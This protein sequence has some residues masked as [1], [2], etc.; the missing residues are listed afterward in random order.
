MAL[1]ACPRCHHATCFECVEDICQNSAFPNKGRCTVCR[2][3]SS[4]I[5][6][7]GFMEEV[8]SYSWIEVNG[9]SGFLSNENPNYLTLLSWNSKALDSNR[10]GTLI[11][12]QNIRVAKIILQKEAEFSFPQ[13]RHSLLFSLAFDFP[14]YGSFIH[15]ALG[16]AWKCKFRRCFTVLSDFA[17]S[18]PKP[19]SADALFM[20]L[21][22][23][24]ALG[25]AIEADTL[26]GY[27]DMSVTQLNT[28]GKL[29]ILPDGRPFWLAGQ[30]TGRVNAAT[31]AASFLERG[32]NYKEVDAVL[33]ASMKFATW[34][35]AKMLMQTEAVELP[36]FFG[37]DAVDA[38]IKKW[39]AAFFESAEY[40]RTVHEPSSFLSLE[41]IGRMQAME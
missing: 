3:E 9:R 13:G 14:S 24:S 5:Y 32:M 7:R 31:F 4:A 36:A 1:C 27:W 16:I 18:C 12:L 22:E 33:F 19:V 39:K 10:T 38:N 28:I 41:D 21:H 8:A 29:E 37:R 23:C 20:F 30:M 35:E 6:L 40:N 17:K 34:M 2:D 15:F 11:N 26:S 25:N